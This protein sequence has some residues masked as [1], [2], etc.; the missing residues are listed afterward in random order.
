[1]KLEVPMLAGL[2]FL[3]TQ[4]LARAQIQGFEG[5]LLSSGVQY[6]LR[7]LRTASTRLRA[8]MTNRPR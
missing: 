6:G 4:L 1:M 5:A 2:I 7:G 8:A 3:G